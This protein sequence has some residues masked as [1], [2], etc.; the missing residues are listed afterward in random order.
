MTTERNIENNV[1]RQDLADYA[2]IRKYIPKPTAHQSRWLKE[3]LDMARRCGVS[4]PVGERVMSAAMLNSKLMD[5][6]LS[7]QMFAG[8]KSTFAMTIR[9]KTKPTAYEISGQMDLFHPEAYQGG[10]N[11]TLR[12]MP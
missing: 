9:R 10:D 11:Q 4:E 1:S 7:L 3:M 6:R 5:K 2:A 8:L 12:Q